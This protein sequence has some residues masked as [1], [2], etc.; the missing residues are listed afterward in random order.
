MK[1][2][3]ESSETIEIDKRKRELQIILNIVEPDPEY[4]PF[5]FFF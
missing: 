4:Q 2:I 3:I 5:F 1:P